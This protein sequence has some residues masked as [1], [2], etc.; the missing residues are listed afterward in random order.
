MLMRVIMQTIRHTLTE[1][2]V[3]LCLA[4][5][6][7]GEIEFRALLIALTY[8]IADPLAVLHALIVDHSV[9]GIYKRSIK[10]YKTHQ[11]ESKTGFFEYRSGAYDTCM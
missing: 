6:D 11:G 10:T 8:R 4:A 5:V 3:T 1:H 9:R 2:V 7:A